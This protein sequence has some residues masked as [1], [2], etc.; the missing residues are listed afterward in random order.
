[1]VVEKGPQQ[2]AYK[3]E[4]VDKLGK[5]QQEFQMLVDKKLAA[6]TYPTE[7]DKLVVTES[8]TYVESADTI[9]VK[10]GLSG[11][12]QDRQEEILKGIRETKEELRKMGWEEPSVVEQEK[13]GKTKMDRILEG[14]EQRG[15]I[16]KREEKS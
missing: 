11:A 7:K 16:K 15:E 9:T 5:L 3:Q 2:E 4:L 10:G 8:G 13:S 1:M 14:M 6:R 12:E